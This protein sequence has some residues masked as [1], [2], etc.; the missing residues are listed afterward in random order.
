MLSELDIL[1]YRVVLEDLRPSGAPFVQDL[2]ED[3]LAD[4]IND[5]SIELRDYQVR[6]R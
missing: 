2:T 5:Y 4:A 3:I 1:T 6:P